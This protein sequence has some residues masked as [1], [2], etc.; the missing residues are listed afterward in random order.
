MLIIRGCAAF[1]DFRLA[2]TLRDLHVIS[3]KIFS[4]RT[5][6]VHFVQLSEQ[7]SDNESEQ[8]YQLLDYGEI[9]TKQTDLGENSLIV[10]PR[11]GTISPW[12]SKATDIAHNCGLNKIVRIERGTIWFI[13]YQND[14]KPS[15]AESAQIKTLIHDRM[16]ETVL[17]KIEQVEQLFHHSAPAEL[18]HIPISESGKQALIEA[19]Q[20]LGLALSDD[21][22][23]YLFDAF[24]EL[25]RDPNDIELMMFAQA[26]SEHCR[27]KI[28]NADWTIDNEKQNLSLFA[29]IKQTHKQNPGRVLSAYH[30]NAAVT[31]GYEA[32]RFFP[33]PES[34][35]YDY[36]SEA[37]HLLMKVETHNHPTAISPYAGAATGAGGEIR[38]EAATGLG[39][40]PKAGMTGFTVSNLQL[41]ELV[42]PWEE[43]NGKPDRIVSALEIMRDAPIGAASY[44]NE[45]GRPALSGYFRS[46]EQKDKSTG[47]IRGF[48]KPIMLAGGYGMLRPNH[49]EKGRIP[50]GAK[51]IVL[52][53]PAMLIGLGGGAAS[54]LASGEGDSELDFASVQR[55]NPEMQRRCQEV[56]DRCWSLGENN[57]IISIHDVGAG[58]LSNA[59]PELI[60]DSKRGAVFNLRQIPNDEPGMSPMEIW[61][62]ESQE[63]Y[64]L[65]ISPE[66][67]E[68]FE[69]LCIRERAPFAVVGEANNSGQLQ[70][71]DSLFENRPIDMPLQVLLG[72]PPRM[73]RTAVR[74]NHKT[75]EF[76]TD[77]IELDSAIERILQLPTVADKSFLITIGDRSISG[78]VVRDQMVG[79]W[80]TP[81]ADCAITASAFDAYVGEAM[82]IGERSPV[83]LLNAPASGRLAIAE[84]ITNICS[85]RILKLDDISFSANWMAACGKLNEDALLFDTVKAVS[86]LAIELGIAIPVGKDSLS[87]STIWTQ[88]EEQRQ[89]ISPLSVIITAFTPVA[90]TRLSLT[91]ELKND[92]NSCLLLVDLSSGQERLGGSCLAQVFNRT[93]GETADLDDSKK[94]I[95]FFSAIQ[96][97]N[98]TGHILA[99][100]DRSDGGMFV[101][102]CEMSFASRIG[103]DIIMPATGRNIL[104]TLFNEEPGVIIQIQKENK[105]SIIETFINSGLNNSDIIEIGSLNNEALIRISKDDDILYSQDM[106]YLHQLWS[107][108]SFYMQ[109]IR[110]NPVCAE[111][112]YARLQDT[113]DPGLSFFTN[114]KMIDSANLP[115]LNI[116]ARPRIAVLREQGVNGQ[117]E[118]AAAYHRAGFES[119]D[120]HMNDLLNGRHSLEEFI[121]LAACGGFSYGD[122]LGAGGGWAKSILFN[123]QLSDIFETFFNRTDTFALGVCNGCQMLSKLT[124]LIPGAAHWPQFVRNSSEQFES[125]L[126]MVEVMDSPSILFTGMVG[127]K[128]PI[129]IAHGEGQVSFTDAKKEPKSQAVLRYIDNHGEQ[130]MLYPAN[131]NG[132]IGGMN[133]F[134][135]DDG[136]FT[137]M[138]PHPER[139]FLRK[140]FSWISDD[141]HHEEGPWMRLFQNAR[142]WVN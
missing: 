141:W 85:T 94:L 70:V 41:P 65:A 93:G 10:V 107:A 73:D 138:M 127:S 81:V 126:V 136:R 21:E 54:S 96:L 37:V 26:N 108:T 47:V 68:I 142:K 115:S 129:L 103:I 27:H 44:N 53:G 6:H 99:Y 36:H 14:Y 35:I 42:Q 80:Q 60:N 32:S 19:N 116:G 106:M 121:G 131:P 64:V 45:F 29:M 18:E 79:A 52:G 125:R 7:L 98:E 67:Y 1:S 69:Q 101:T 78:L 17:E 130:T 49:V 112:E 90:D 51:I 117:V 123:Q 86:D 50:I 12:S 87:M 109:T 118:M 122:V 3:S 2:N 59:L 28:F 23:D 139:V 135:N 77:G 55:D 34:H 105:A 100:H 38:D 82:S 39:G 62:N 20:N 63:R 140:Q 43:D 25:G 124:N 66:S 24:N 58:G 83:A 61:C 13:E 72:K 75:D 31:T 88:E 137:I 84:A 128:I 76:D 33:T 56:V 71:D 74:D 95:S 113:K 40:K 46:Y 15:L 5:E 30:D 110:D 91:P 9:T 111:Q 119:V 104:A 92:N 8:L 133:G 16:T 11:P 97:L 132:S 48:H 114:F 102:L 4:L 89:V 134:C 57:P 120:V 22:I